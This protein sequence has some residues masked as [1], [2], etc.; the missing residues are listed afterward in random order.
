MSFNKINEELDLIITQIE[1]EVCIEN[2]IRV[3]K[4]GI[5]K[6]D[7]LDKIIDNE[8]QK[9]NNLKVNKDKTNNVSEDENIFEISKQIEN[10]YELFNDN[11]PIEDLYKLYKKSIILKNKANLVYNK[12]LNIKYI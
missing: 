7:L 8:K 10:I 1:N 9:I 4:E 6:C 5:K 12:K 3:Y 11:I 2:Q